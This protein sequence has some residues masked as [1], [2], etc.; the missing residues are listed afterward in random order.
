MRPVPSAWIVSFISCGFFVAAACAQDNRPLDTE[1]S[2]AL[3]LPIEKGLD[4]VVTKCPI[5]IN[6]ATIV[7]AKAILRVIYV[8]PR[9]DDDRLRAIRSKN[10]SDASWTRDNRLNQSDKLSPS[11][12]ALIE[13]SRNTVWTEVTPFQL[14]LTNL[15]ADDLRMAYIIPGTTPENFQFF[16]QR[17]NFPEGLILVETSGTVSVL[18][19]D[20]NKAAAKAGIKAGETI[21][22]VGDRPTNG[23]LAT[24]LDN[25]HAVRKATTMAMKTSFAMTV[26][27]ADGAERDVTI[28]L[29]PS[30]GAGFLDAPIVDSTS[31]N[32][33]AKPAP[34]A[35]VVPEVWEKKKPTQPA[36]PNP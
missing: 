9:L 24:F 36:A 6:D 21:T 22:K 32:K 23:S 5:L 12:L 28:K 19:V 16:D 11:Q 35:V 14:A 34:A 30:I 1:P 33:S 15:G 8:P 25:Y 2:L 26:K 13:V 31:S 18:A 27:G 20:K 3:V 29:P 17:L 4:N 7:P 10:N